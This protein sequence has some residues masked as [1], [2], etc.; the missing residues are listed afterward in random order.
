ME[1]SHFLIF[2]LVQYCTF[3]QMLDFLYLQST[4]SNSHSYLL[5][6]LHLIPYSPRVMKTLPPLLFFNLQHIRR[7]LL[8]TSSYSYQTD[9]CYLVFFNLH[10]LLCFLF[11]SFLKTHAHWK[12]IFTF[13]L[14]SLHFI[15]TYLVLLNSTFW[16]IST[17]LFIFIMQMLIS[18][19]QTNQ[20]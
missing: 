10:T 6:R 4:I 5:H 9:L 18:F 19:S 16:W 14:C 7:P 3:Y 13:S 8:S 15:F 17:F 2:V 20:K 12:F 1:F 11:S